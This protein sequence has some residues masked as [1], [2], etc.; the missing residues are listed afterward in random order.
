MKSVDQIPPEIWEI[1]RYYMP[2]LDYHAIRNIN[3]E[4]RKMKLSLAEFKTRE[5]FRGR[6]L[7]ILAHHQD[8]LKNPS[9]TD[10][11]HLISLDPGLATNDDINFLATNCFFRKLYRL[12]T[13]RHDLEA[14]VGGTLLRDACIMGHA[15]L[16][17]YLLKNPNNRYIPINPSAVMSHTARNNSVEVYDVLLKDRRFSPSVQN[18]WP[19][20]MASKLGYLEIVD[21]SLRDCRVDPSDC[22]NSAIKLAAKNGHWDVVDRLKLDPRVDASVISKFKR[23]FNI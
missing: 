9:F 8:L 17:Q 7:P 11:S 13:S 1:I 16:V 18:N 6:P 4:T 2:V 20:R 12:L 3:H 14:Y 15:L 22:N 21:M 19:I 5:I 23:P 10:L